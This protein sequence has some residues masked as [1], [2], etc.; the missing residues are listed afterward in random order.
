MERK[1]EIVPVG[2][3][4]IFPEGQPLVIAGPC[5]AESEIQV[6]E[7]ARRIKTLGVNVFRAGIWKP[8]THPGTFE[9]VGTP[10]LK[11]M[12]RVKN[13]L[14]M[15]ISTEVASERVRLSE[16]RGGYGM[17]RSQDYGQSVF[18]SG[19]SRCIEGRGY[20]G[21]GEKPCQP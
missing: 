1:L 3:W 20:S 21:A 13:E 2:K 19:D 10:G 5:S 6:M 7:T 16:I 14:G 11:W 15:K 17:A 9:G 12:Q 18:G 8:R 4:G